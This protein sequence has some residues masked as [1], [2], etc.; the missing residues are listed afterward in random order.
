[1]SALPQ[2]SILLP[3]LVAFIAIVVIGYFIAKALEKILDKVLERVSFNGW[4][5][6]VA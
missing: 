1:M 4:V 3:K 5:E 2:N 6:R